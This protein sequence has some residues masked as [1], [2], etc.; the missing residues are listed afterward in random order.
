MR[1]FAL[2]VVVFAS[3]LQAAELRRFSTPQYVLLPVMAATNI[4][5]GF[6]PPS[7]SRWQGGVLFDDGLRDLLRLKSDGGRT[8]IK[9]TGDLLLYSLLMYPLA[10]DA[11]LNTMIS[12]NDTDTGGQLMLIAAQSF[13]IS[14]ALTVVTKTLTARERPYQ[15]EC[16][17]NPT[18]DVSCGEPDSRRSFFSG[19]SSLAFTGAGL[20]CAT[21]QAFDL[22]G[23]MTPCYVGL[24]LATITALS[25]IMSDRHYG[26]DILVGAAVGGLSGYFL[27]KWLHYRRG[28]SLTVGATPFGLM[29]SWPI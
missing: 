9:Y 23:G 24:G 5:V 13:L 6:S 11:G 19:H 25:R 15:R 8:A 21:H 14:G 28:S 20:I 12:G 16:A 29:L 27:P 22:W 17:V 18:Y 3:T 4:V 2:A 26:T 1:S 7:Q 10:V